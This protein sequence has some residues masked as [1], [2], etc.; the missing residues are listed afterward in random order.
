MYRMILVGDRFDRQDSSGSH[1]RFR[2]GSLR[3]I[4]VKL[5]EG[6]PERQ[7]E[8]ALKTRNISIGSGGGRARVLAPILAS[9]ERLALPPTVT[10]RMPT[11]A[12]LGSV[13]G[14]ERAD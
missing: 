11:G 2:S 9:V 13:T 7:F 12:S 1:H 14:S 6:G 3:P 5:I 8:N 10:S 4:A